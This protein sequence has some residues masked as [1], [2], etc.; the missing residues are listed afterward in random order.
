MSVGST[1]SCHS[2]IVMVCVT[3][4][5]SSSVVISP[6]VLLEAVQPVQPPHGGTTVCR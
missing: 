6:G 5:D 4:W 3:S 2:A 1:P